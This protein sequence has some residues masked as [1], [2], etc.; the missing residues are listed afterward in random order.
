M[1][2]ARYRAIRFEHPALAT[3]DEP[4]GLGV[5]DHRLRTVAGDASVRQAILL[6]LS[7]RPG[8]R[9]ML[10]TYGCD[11]HTLVFQPNDDTTAGLAAHFV[12]RALE[13]WEPRIELLSVEA[14]RDREDDARL[15]ITV[16]Y[17]VRATQRRE[18]LELPFSLEGGLR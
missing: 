7:T 13:R 1:T 11:L 9:V 12:R 18:R 6:L 2:T 17:R 14:W 8:E 3:D 16:E 15:A 5:A 4:E 10:P